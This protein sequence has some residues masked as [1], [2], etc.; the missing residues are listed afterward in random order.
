[1]REPIAL[2]YLLARLSDTI[3]DTTSAPLAERVAALAS[4]REGRL[5]QLDALSDQLAH[6]GEKELCLRAGEIFDWLHQIPEREQQ[7][8]EQVLATITTGQA[9]DLEHFADPGASANEADLERYTYQVAGC[10]GEFWTKVGYLKLGEKFAS[11]NDREQLLTSGRSLGQGLQL[12]N[13]LRDLHE[14]LPAG[15]LYLGSAEPDQE[16]FETH[17]KKCRHY[18]SDGHQYLPPLR[19]RRVRTATALPLYLAEATADLLEESGVETVRQRKVKVSRS[20]VW[21]TILRTLT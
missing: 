7:L 1:M 16:L 2:G 14:D 19:N 5:P 13:I 20:E 3:A 11:E 15:R 12:I 4:L 10:V 17:L 18:L 9:W 21:H 6:P 8:I